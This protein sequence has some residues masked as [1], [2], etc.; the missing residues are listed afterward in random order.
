MLSTGWKLNWTAGH[1]ESHC[2]ACKPP[3]SMQHHEWIEIKY[4]RTF[5][6]SCFFFVRCSVGFLFCGF[7]AEVLT[8]VAP[9]SAASTPA[10]TANK[11]LV[12]KKKKSVKAKKRQG[13]PWNHGS[14]VL[15][16]L[17][18]LF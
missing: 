13:M 12:P 17:L 7:L 6:V 9:T 4:E 11:T 5:F 3:V 2:P 14:P 8:E 16:R 1:F 10:S 15:I 18:L